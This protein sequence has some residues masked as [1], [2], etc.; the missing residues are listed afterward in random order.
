MSTA[1]PFVRAGRP[2]LLAV[3]SKRRFAL[4]PD[5]PTVAEA[6][7][8]GCGSSAWYGLWAPAGTPTDI[9]A[10]LNRDATRILTTA[11]LKDQLVTQGLEPIPV[12][13]KVFAAARRT[14]IDQWAQIIRSAGVKPE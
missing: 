13:P 5:A 6:G 4:F 2:K 12:A 10:K 3:T 14:E 7:V 8:P 1:L 9:V 11:P